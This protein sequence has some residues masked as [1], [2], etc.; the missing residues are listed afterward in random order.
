MPRAAPRCPTGG[1]AWAVPQQQQ[2]KRQ[3]FPWNAEP[4][5]PVLSP[6]SVAV[7]GDEL[8]GITHTALGTAPKINPA[9]AGCLW[10]DGAGSALPWHLT[11]A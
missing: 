5:V 4:P 11:C 10:G 3:G 9:S 2:R 6:R 1:G 7:Q 8:A